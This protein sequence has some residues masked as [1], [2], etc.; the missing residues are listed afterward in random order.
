MNSERPMKSMSSCLNIN[1][2]CQVNSEQPDT[3]EDEEEMEINDDG[4]QVN[5][6]ISS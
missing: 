3:E 5:W 6:K 2:P 1:S 4:I